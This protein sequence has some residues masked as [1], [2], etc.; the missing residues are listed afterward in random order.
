MSRCC[1]RRKGT[2]FTDFVLKQRLARAH[3]M[4]T[5]PRYAGQKIAALADEVGFD[6]RSDFVR[7][8]RRQYGMAPSEVREAALRAGA[9]PNPTIA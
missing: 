6:E 3:R 2:T 8:F 1:S 9:Q 5:D 4:L 7:R